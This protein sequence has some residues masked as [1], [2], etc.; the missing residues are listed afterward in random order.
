MRFGLNTLKRFPLTSAILRFC[1]KW[2]LTDMASR[3]AIRFY[4]SNQ[5]II[6]FLLAQASENKRG[7]S[8]IKTSANSISLPSQ[9]GTWMFQYIAKARC[10]AP[11][12]TLHSLPPYLL[13]ELVP[14]LLTGST[15]CDKKHFKLSKPIAKDEQPIE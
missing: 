3:T 8:L 2:L 7:L 5:I 4:S 11:S 10:K 13:Q 9:T 12:G 1:N 6:F 15:T 14:C